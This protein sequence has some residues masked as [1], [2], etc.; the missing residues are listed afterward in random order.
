[1]HKF[2][3]NLVTGPTVEP[4]TIA[5]AKLHLRVDFD[6]DDTLI[7]ALIQ[8]AREYIENYTNSALFA[9][10]WL[11]TLDQFP[12]P[13]S[14]STIS[15]AARDN[16]LGVGGY[17]D[18]MQMLLP[19]PKCQSVTSITYID[20]SNTQRTLDPTT[21]NLDI[22]SIPARILPVDGGTWPYPAVY[23][24]GTVQ[25]TFVAGSYTPATCPASL[26]QAMLLLIGAWYGQREAISEKPM[27][28]VPFAVECLLAPYRNYQLVL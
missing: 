15:P 5:F 21:Y 26:Q 3:L 6:D 19:V 14:F 20:G 13:Q 8:A 18:G 4:I 27:S 9:Q 7:S 24:S 2:G 22:N 10:T 12:Y 16:W 28:A 1:M 17:L 25:V 23:V 11:L